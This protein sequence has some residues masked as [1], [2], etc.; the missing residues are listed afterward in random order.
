MAFVPIQSS[1]KPTCAPL[2]VSTELMEDLVVLD[3]W[4]WLRLVVKRTVAVGFGECSAKDR[5]RQQ[6]Q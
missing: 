5:V 2:F 1:H 6:S 3:H 4:F